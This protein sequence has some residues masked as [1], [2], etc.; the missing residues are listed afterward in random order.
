M[1][2][3]KIQGMTCQHCVMAVTKALGKLSG[4]ENVKVDLAKGEAVFENTRN[5]PPAAIRQ[6]VEDAGYKV[7]E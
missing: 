7:G 6:A 2:K 4:L 1:E 5:I 3:I